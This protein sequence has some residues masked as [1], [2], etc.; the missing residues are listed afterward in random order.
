MD[1]FIVVEEFIDK[2]V[3]YEF[4]QYGFGIDFRRT[5]KLPILLKVV[6]KET[7]T[8]ILNSFIACFSKKRYK[9]MLKKAIENRDRKNYLLS[10]KEE[11]NIFHKE[12]N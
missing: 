7:N 3:V 8:E 1:I 11:F 2:E 4:K 10:H 5:H 6:D 9:S 12:E